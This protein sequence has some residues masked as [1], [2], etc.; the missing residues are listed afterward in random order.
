MG[1]RYT[2]NQYIFVRRGI[3]I[4]L[5]SIDIH[6]LLFRLEHEFYDFPFSWE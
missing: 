2:T 4:P 3:I 1:D 6:W 5:K